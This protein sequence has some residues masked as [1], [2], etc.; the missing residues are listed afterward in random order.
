MNEAAASIPWS[1]LPEAVARV[2]RHLGCTPEAAELQIISNGKSDRIKARGVIEGQSVPLQ[3]V[4]E[5]KGSWS[6]THG[7]I[8]SRPV[9][10]LPAAWNG[11]IN[12]TAAT[13][14]PPGVPYEI[15]NIELCFIDLVAAGLLPEPTEKVCWSVEEAVAYW[16]KGVPLLWG[17]WQMAGASPAEIE[18]A[19][20]DLGELISAGMVPAWGWHPLERRRKR[21]PSD[22]FRVEMIARKEVL[23]VSVTRL[24]KVVVHIDG[25]VGIS[26]LSRTADYIGPRWERIEV[27]SAALRQARLRSAEPKPAPPSTL[28]VSKLTLMVPPVEAPLAPPSAQEPTPTTP[29]TLP[30]TPEMILSALGI[31][32]FQQEAIAK[33]VVEHKLDLPED[34]KPADLRDTIRKL[35]TAKARARGDTP[36]NPPGWD[37][38]DHFVKAVRAYRAKP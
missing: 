19:E 33:A 34:L 38:C 27:D 31:R 11:T 21:I 18:Q 14:K 26:P 9:S 6:K 32:G 10:L 24:L 37:A 28:A 25:T 20:I 3:I 15:T 30:N 17:A 16:V 5:G 2:A 22:H 4:G 7:V 23:P 8:E 35:Q 12:L 29:K 1:P 13:I 36:P